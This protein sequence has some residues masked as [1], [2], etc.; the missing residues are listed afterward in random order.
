[1]KEWCKVSC[2]KIIALLTVVYEGSNTLV[3]Y[4]FEYVAECSAESGVKFHEK[5][6]I[7]LK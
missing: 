4:I 1:M 2:V 5:L 7:A 6:N 3:L